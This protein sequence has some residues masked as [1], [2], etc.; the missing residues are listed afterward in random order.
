MREVL[1]AQREDIRN[2]LLGT[3]LTLGL[4]DDPDLS[5]AQKQQ[6][7]DDREFLKRRLPQVERE[8]AT[9]PERIQGLYEDRQHHVE[10]VGIV[11]LWPATS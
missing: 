11:Y 5:D 1:E 2:A 10:I 8:L 7:K 4:G 6:W 9:E 3:Q